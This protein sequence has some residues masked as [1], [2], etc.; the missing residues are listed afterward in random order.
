MADSSCGKKSTKCPNCSSASQRNVLCVCSCK[1]KLS[2]MSVVE[3]SQTSST[4]SSEF[5]VSPERKKERQ[6]S[7]DSTSGKDLV[8]IEDSTQVDVP[9]P[10]P[11]PRFIH[12]PWTLVSQFIAFLTIKV[13]FLSYIRGERSWLIISFMLFPTTAQVNDFPGL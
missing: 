10:D 4:G 9:F 1:T 12:I 5:T 3:M 11:I 13:T 2:P 7:K 8:N 6:A